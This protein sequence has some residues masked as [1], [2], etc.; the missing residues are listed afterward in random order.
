MHESWGGGVGKSQKE[1]IMWG[2]IRKIEKHLAMVGKE[3]L[4]LCE[5]DLDADGSVL[6]FC[7]P[8][9]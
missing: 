5:A 4:L 7:V 6:V 9:C 3:I 8:C 2:I 1:R